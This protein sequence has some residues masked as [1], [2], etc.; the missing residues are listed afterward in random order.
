MTDKTIQS[1]ANEKTGLIASDLE[2]NKVG[3]KPQQDFELKQIHQKENNENTK[4][5]TES[6]NNIGLKEP[7]SGATITWSFILINLTFLL[8][9]LPEL[10]CFS[11]I[12]II[13]LYIS[14]LIW[15]QNDLSAITKLVLIITFLFL[16]YRIGL[17]MFESA[18]QAM[19]PD[20][21]W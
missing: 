18:W 20:F 21:S 15:I 11:I 8:F 19:G 5:L 2:L 3:E 13:P 1:R 6:N 9:N 7:I 12:V 10:V 17:F 4:K 14:C 16:L